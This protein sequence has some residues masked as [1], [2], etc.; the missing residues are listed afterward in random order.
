MKDGTMLALDLGTTTGW[1][2]HRC[3]RVY[4][5]TWKLVPPSRLEGGGMR[6]LRFENQLL[7]ML[8]LC[9]ETRHPVT[10]VYF[11][12]V[13]RHAGTDAAHVYGG[14]VA[15]LM[16]TLEEE[17]IPFAGLPVKTVKKLFAGNGNAGKELMISTAKSKYPDQQIADDNQADALAILATGIAQEGGE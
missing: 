4:S 9:S 10:R 6:Y 13:E 14:L 2:V 11:E 5:G 3:G 1:A 16:K 15:I 8:K 7:E 12:E 17:K